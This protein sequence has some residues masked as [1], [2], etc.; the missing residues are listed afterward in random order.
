LKG[1]SSLLTWTKLEK[2]ANSVFYSHL[3]KL[4]T[5]LRNTSICIPT[6]K[7]SLLKTKETTIWWELIKSRTTV[8]NTS[9]DLLLTENLNRWMKKEEA[10]RWNREWDSHLWEWSSDLL[11]RRMS[12]CK[13]SRLDK[14]SMNRSLRSKSLSS[15]MLA[16]PKVAHW[17]PDTESKRACS[18]TN[19][20]SCTQIQWEK[21]K[22]QRLTWPKRRLRC[23]ELLM[24]TLSVP[25]KAEEKVESELIAMGKE[26]WAIDLV[27]QHL[28][29][30]E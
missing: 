30:Q 11:C 20:N 10:L 16:E 9:I 27:K 12:I 7:I 19:G 18:K 28:L 14:L 4:N 1:N 2:K 5:Q 6:A 13:E 23:R 24:N 25:I 3:K 17:L 29:R 15:Q 22:T 8:N 26:I 21:L